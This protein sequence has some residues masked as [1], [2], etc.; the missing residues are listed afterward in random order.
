MCV[1][2]KAVAFAE[3]GFIPCDFGGDWRAPKREEGVV[4]GF[5]VDEGVQVAY[6]E[7]GAYFT[8]FCLLLRPVCSLAFFPS[9]AGGRGGKGSLGRKLPY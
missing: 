2:D 7:L 8:G 9:I 1:G 5:F 4:E 3:P 6:E